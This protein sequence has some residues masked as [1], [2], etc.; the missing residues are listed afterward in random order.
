[1]Q[2]LEIN[3]RIM[4]I[5]FGEL[6]LRGK[7]RNRYISRLIRNITQGLNNE[8]FSLV[9]YYDRII[10]R[11][12]K[13]SN[14]ESIEKKIKRVFGISAYEFAVVGKPTL[15]SIKKI[16]LYKIKDIDPKTVKTIKKNIAQI[17]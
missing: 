17:I 14:I 6:W 9:Y 10:L 7:N 3:E 4:I 16:F 1:M 12:S 11:F 2:P 5:H 8:L 13:D 15:E